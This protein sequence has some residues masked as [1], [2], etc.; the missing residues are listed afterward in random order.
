LQSIGQQIVKALKGCP[1]VARSVGALLNRNLTYEHWRTVQNKWKSLQED[2]DGIILK[3]SY[4]FLPVHLQHCFSYYSLFPEDYQFDGGNLVHAWI[5]QNFVQ[6]EDPSM[7]LEETGKQYLD[8]LVDLGFFQKVGSDYVMHDLMHELA[9]MVSR[10]DCATVNG[11]NSRDI[12]PSVRHLLVI[13]AAYEKDGH[14]TI[15][16]EKILENIGFSK[17]LRTLMVFGRG[18]IRL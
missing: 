2:I 8:N 1:L 5:S 18:G 14:C 7:R 11:S 15:T 3:L 4:D 10:N 6:C 17:R 9:H 16:F 13:I 12:P